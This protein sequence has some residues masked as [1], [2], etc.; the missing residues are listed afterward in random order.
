MFF[1]ATAAIFALGC[2]AA[3]GLQGDSA[4]AG[5]DISWYTRN[6]EATLFRIQNAGQLAGLAALVN[7]EVGLGRSIDFSGRVIVLARN[8][9]LSSYGK[10]AR[11]NN[12][13]GW[14]PIGR[15][16]ADGN[17]LSFKG[18]FDGNGR[19][20]RGLYIGNDQLTN[21]GLFGVIDG[22]DPAA[23]AN[24]A[25]TSARGRAGALG[26]TVMNLGLTGVEIAGKEFVGG[27]VG[28]L[29]RG[30][31]SNVYITGSVSGSVGVGGL[32]G[33]IG[34]GRV[35]NSYSAAAVKGATNVGGIAGNVA[36]GGSVV[37]C[38]AAG[39]VSGGVAVG[40][41]V[42]N[43]EENGSVTSN[44][45]L[46]PSLF[47]IGRQ[48]G[49]VGR[50]VGLNSG[51]LYGNVALRDMTDAV[52][53]IAW[54]NKGTTETDG[55]DISIGGVRADR[56][57]GG[58]FKSNNGWTLKTGRL[59]GIGAAVA[60]P[61]HFSAGYRAAVSPAY[62]WYTGDRG[63][64]S[65]TIFTAEQLAGLAAIVNGTWG[66]TPARDDFS[67]KTITLAADVDLSVYENW[68]PIGDYENNNGNIFQGTFSGGG[69]TIRGLTINRNTADYQGLFGYVRHGRVEKVVMDGVNIRARDFL[70]G[71][72]GYLCISSSVDNS[73]SAGAIAGV[74]QHTDGVVGFVH[75]SSRVSNSTSTIEVTTRAAT[76]GSITIANK[77]GYTIIRAYVS[78]VGANVWGN[79]LLV[80]GRVVDGDSFTV[81]TLPTSN[82][83]MYDIRLVD[84]DEDSYVMRNVNLEQNQDIEFTFARF[85]TNS[86][87]VNNRN[88]G[89]GDPSERRRER[90]ERSDCSSCLINAENDRAENANDTGRVTTITITN[91][92]G[93]AVLSVFISPVG[94]STWGNELLGDNNLGNG[95]SFTFTSLPPS[96]GNMYD[97]RLVDTDEDS[98]VIRGVRLREG[99]TINF[100]FND[101]VRGGRGRH[102]RQNLNGRDACGL[103]RNDNRGSADP[104]DTTTVTTLTIKN[105]T[106]YGVTRAYIV[107]A[108]S[109][110]W[111]NDRLGSNTLGDNGTF[112]F[113]SL[114]RSENNTYN[115]RLVDSDE[116]SYTI[117]N[118]RLS[119]GQTLEFTFDDFDGGGIGDG[120]DNEND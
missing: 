80:S 104:N 10:G 58:I 89:L 111:G 40:G 74:G 47:G 50:V 49:G 14:I 26:T 55:A 44:A 23:D 94:D 35:A 56:T 109:S 98:Y 69:H 8:I 113:T 52:G 110:S 15:K 6:P 67:G 18:V 39:A 22:L 63:A 116:D 108:A 42:G 72:V 76:A 5:T 101:I 12:G 103:H 70:G 19:S 62:V 66:G 24:R 34:N 86:R 68:V 33:S 48:A 97:I 25:D 78:P 41:V 20:I 31:L 11:F 29:V 90:R 107:P 38:Y 4:A 32:A 118:I 27:L 54:N 59:P 75:E 73:S 53:E 88:L 71:V 65:F 30:T 117:R 28:S 2:G 21:A 51:K 36:A 83:G 46:N 13:K 106:G 85:V 17:T 105:S 82:D 112:T 3:S 61:A 81:S 16:G 84:T 60:L 120:E 79:N 91:R 99:Q 96:N 64:A 92:T 87:R 100:R 57:L 77:T 45:A 43:V 7:N 37:N 95:Q 102:D 119:Q 1:V 93:Y 115:V 114:P 9:D